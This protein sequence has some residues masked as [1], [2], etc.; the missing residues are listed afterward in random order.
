MFLQYFLSMTLVITCINSQ[1][2][3]VNPTTQENQLLFDP[4][5]TTTASPQFARCMDSCRT[6]QHY[7]P[8]CGSDGQTYNN[9]FR[10]QCAQRCGQSVF[11]A[12]GGSC[13][14]L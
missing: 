8:V 14:S 11:L 5:T 12:R 7:N 13:Q 9:E 2:N 6:V 10:L 1:L 3:E 4:S